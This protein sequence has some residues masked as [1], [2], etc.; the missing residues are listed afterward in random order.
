MAKSVMGVCQMTGTPTESR[1]A[2]LTGGNSTLNIQA[3]RQVPIFSAGIFSQMQVLV[4][5]N[6]ADGTITFTFQIAGSSA[7][8]SVPVLTTATGLFADITNTDAVTTGQLVN[9]AS[10]PTSG[11]AGTVVA[12][13]SVSFAATSNTAE[14]FIINGAVGFTDNTATV[15]YLP[16]VGAEPSGGGAVQETTE[17]ITQFT[18]KTG[19]TL[20][21]GAWYVNTNARTVTAT[22]TSRIN[23]ANGA[24][25]I[26]VTTLATGLFQDTSNTDTIVSG[27]KLN[28]AITSAPAEANDVSGNFLSCEFITTDSSWQMIVGS[29]TVGGTSWI[30]S[31]VEYLRTTGSASVIDST[32][33]NMTTKI[34]FACTASNINIYVVVNAGT[35]NGD[36]TLMKN[37]SATSLSAVITAL[38]TGLFVDDSNT[39]SIAAN[40][41]ISLRLDT[42]ATG[43]T[44]TGAFGLKMLTTAAASAS[45]S[46]GLPNFLL[47]GVG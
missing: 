24:I 11:T 34:P 13:T 20:R 44:L 36:L 21:N 45:G 39:S 28:W 19:G 38:T 29:Q 2:T 7:T 5:S 8:L 4:L 41:L 17:A 42:G 46:G 32:E 15:I 18:M 40:D 22:A 35:T 9:F 23:G 26:P 33:A 6:S 31:D 25:S 16:L 10:I 37:G 1:Y 3:R 27:N 47:L 43:A 30:A 12:R 14:L